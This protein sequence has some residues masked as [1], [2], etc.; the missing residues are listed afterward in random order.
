MPREVSDLIGI[1]TIEKRN[2]ERGAGPHA[3]K[4]VTVDHELNKMRFFSSVLHLRGDHV[5]VQPHQREED[6]L[7]WN[8]EV[9]ELCRL[10]RDYTILF[11]L[12]DLR[13]LGH[14]LDRERWSQT[15]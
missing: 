10:S 9:F 3:Q 15:L 2:N 1:V 8:G 5:A 11:V 12:S 13:R 6:I 14:S 7:C 4:T